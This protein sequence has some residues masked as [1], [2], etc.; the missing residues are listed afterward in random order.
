M[1]NDALLSSK[2]DDWATPPDF[3]DRLD[4]IFNFQLDAAASPHN[5]KCSTFFTKTQNGLAQSWHPF[6]RIWLNPPYGRGIE[7]WMQKAYEEANEGCVVVCLVSARTD[8]RW[9]HDWVKN[10][11]KVTFIKR[12]L[13]F[14]NPDVC[15][16]GRGNSVF[17][18]ALVIYGLDFDYIL[19]QG[20]G[21]CVGRSR[22]SER[23]QCL[24]CANADRTEDV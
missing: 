16:D 8:T 20:S 6:K 18:S 3:F 11:A 15:P 24:E 10:K 12:R 1:I 23:S 13:K 7:Q 2:S 5:A 17:A 19:N 14:R 4:E 9:W 21:L 22:A